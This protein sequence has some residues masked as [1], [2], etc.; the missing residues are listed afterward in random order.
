LSDHHNNEFTKLQI[1][2][3]VLGQASVTAHFSEIAIEI[4]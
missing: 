3:S 2:H 4:T 1:A